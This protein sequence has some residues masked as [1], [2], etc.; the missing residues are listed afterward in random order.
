MDIL[1][2]GTKNKK[3]ELAFL[4]IDHHKRG[5]FD[6]A[7]LRELIESTITVWTHLTGNHLSKYKRFK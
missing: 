4:M 1:L 6:K 3:N 2:N 5:F 7:D